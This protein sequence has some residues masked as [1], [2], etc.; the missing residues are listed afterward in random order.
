MAVKLHEQE[1]LS[2]VVQPQ[3]AAEAAALLAGSAGNAV[4]VAGGTLLR[5]QWEA[6]T[7]KMPGQLI[8]LSKLPGIAGITERPDGV[9]IGAMTNLAE[10]RLSERLQQSFPLLVEAARVIAAPSIRNLATIGGNIV[11]GVGDALPALLVYDAL[12]HW[13]DG[14]TET[15][16]RAAEWL[17]NPRKDRV[18]LGVEL[19]FQASAAGLDSDANIKRMTAFHKVGRREAFIPSLVT[20][21]MDGL[22]D[23]EAGRWREFKLA[24]GGGQTPPSRLSA[25]EDYLQNRIAEPGALQSVST[26][27]MDEY[28]PIG[29]AFAS[30]QYRKTAAANL[31][32][33][34]LWKSIREIN[35]KGDGSGCS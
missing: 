12:L 15:T 6:G 19:R 18:L 20:V 7:V 5:T 22:L 31:V 2:S 13:H 16:E 29:D 3:S 35:R 30:V 1:R 14:L 11:Y 23:K 25:A 8:D 9:T 17:L 28:N 10:C 21:A 26:L 4:F 33:A 27:I 32:T 24:L 34:E